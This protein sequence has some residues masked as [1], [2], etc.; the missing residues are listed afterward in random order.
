MAPIHSGRILFRL[1]ERAAGRGMAKRNDQHDAFP[2][3][4]PSE[5]LGVG[6]NGNG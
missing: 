3:A 5:R 4:F 1:G 6:G 2:E